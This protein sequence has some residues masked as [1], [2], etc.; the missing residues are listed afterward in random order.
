[1]TKDSVI[2]FLVQFAGTPVGVGVLTAVAISAVKSV[3]RLLRGLFTG[4]CRAPERIL[5]G[6]LNVIDRKASAKGGGLL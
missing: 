3:P 5:M 6:V 2:A 4:I 1:M